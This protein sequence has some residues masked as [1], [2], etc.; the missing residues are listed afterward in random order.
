MISLDVEGVGSLLRFLGV[1]WRTVNVKNNPCMIK[2][3]HVNCKINLHDR[4]LESTD[5]T[6][7]RL[8]SKSFMKMNEN[9]KKH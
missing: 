5:L 6:E 7:D 2:I 1:E 9:T 3:N 8:E 4:F